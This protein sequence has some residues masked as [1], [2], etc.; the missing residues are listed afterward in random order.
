MCA[1]DLVL[2]RVES[3]AHAGIQTVD[4]QAYCLF[5]IQS[6]I[7]RAFNRMEVEKV[8]W[9]AVITLSNT[10]ILWHKVKL[11]RKMLPVCAFHGVFL[12]WA[13]DWSEWSASHSVEF[14]SGER[15]HDTHPTR[16]WLQ[17]EVSF[18]VK[19]TSRQFNTWLRCVL[20]L[21]D[22]LHI[23]QMQSVGNWGVGGG[24]IVQSSYTELDLVGG[25]LGILQH[26]V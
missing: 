13:L 20:F 3:L 24:S 2:R 21:P 9:W 10:G 17:P 23:F 7:S 26:C 22:I 4:H 18:D 8:M 14:M 12:N 5:T 11:K 15:V 1:T 19:W 16:G 6:T 25:Q